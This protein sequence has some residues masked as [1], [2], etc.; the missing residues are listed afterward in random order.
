MTTIDTGSSGTGGTVD[1]KGLKGGSLGLLSSVVVGMASTAPAYSLAAV[2]G[3]IV[4][5]GAGVKAASIV[6]L[7]FVPIYLIAVAYQELNKAEPD[8]GTT[9]TWASRAFGPL[10]GWMGGWGIIAADVIVM[11]NLAQIA[12]A[13][14]FTFV[15]DLGWHSVADLANSTLWST[16][17]GVI[18]IVVMTYIC[19]R[20]IEVS[21]RLQY[22]LLGFEVIV[23]IV[24]SVYA[25]IRVYSGTG[26]VDSIHPSLSWFSPVGLDFGTIIC[27]GILIAIF[28][29]WGWDTAVACN[30]ESDD[31]G[32]TPGKAAVL[33]TFLLLGTYAIVTVASI[34][35]AGV[36]DTGPGLTNPDNAADVFSSIGPALFGDSFIGHVG[37]LALSATIL[38]SASASTQTTILPTARTTLSM[39]V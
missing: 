25:L 32:S 38:T 20:G 1:S 37:L 19:Y 2:L 4:A 31:P 13:Y 18:W 5:T 3:L 28:I 30:E 15:G 27:P 17:A 7:A 22:F 39:G 10:I 35:F 34:A 36:G 23:L 33:S 12:G 21:A 29:Y 11:A 14:S 16:V 26:T 8:C 24:I 6:L 9:F